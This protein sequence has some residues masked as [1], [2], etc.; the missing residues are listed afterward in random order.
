MSESSTMFCGECGRGP[1]EAS[2]AGAYLARTNPKGE[3]GAWRCEP[4]C[5]GKQDGP[6][7]AVVGAIEGETLLKKATKV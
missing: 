7:A 4:A 3:V 6:E 5:K 2:E 1:L